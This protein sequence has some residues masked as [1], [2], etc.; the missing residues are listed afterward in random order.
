MGKKG[1]LQVQS[2]RLLVEESAEVKTS[3][4][5]DHEIECPRCHNIMTSSPNF[6]RLGYFCEQCDLS[7]V[8]KL[9][10]YENCRSQC[11]I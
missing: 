1:S 4:E 3:A 7:N 8:N 10:R 6:D 11:S 2:N 5:L 9:D